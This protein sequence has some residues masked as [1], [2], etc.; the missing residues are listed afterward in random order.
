MVTITQAELAGWAG[1][2]REA[3]NKALSRLS[4]RGLVVL[5]RGHLTVIDLD[6]LRARAG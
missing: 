3:A 1:C 5:G 4:D 6:G 2:S